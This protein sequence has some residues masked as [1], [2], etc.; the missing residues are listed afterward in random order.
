MT[1][2][3]LV[4][5]V[6]AI[7]AVVDGVSGIEA[8]PAI[9]KENLNN[10][11]FALTYVMTS[12][13][14]ISETGTKQHLVLIAIDLLRPLVNLNNELTILLP[15]V[16]AVSTA[17]I[18]EMTSGGDAFSNTIDT[19]SILRIEFLPSYTYSAVDCI[20]YRIMM[21]DTKLKLDL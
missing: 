3:T 19:F 6:T 21:E 20:G 13:V 7:A 10:R 14:E 11:T 12:A 5:A 18:T 15:I 17:L 4:G 16:D 8:A 1:A 2:Q 9:P